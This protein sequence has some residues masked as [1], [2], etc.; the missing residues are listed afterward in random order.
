V[1]IV[2]GEG[3]VDALAKLGITATCCAEGAGKWRVEHAKWLAGA[4]VVILPDH[5]DRGREHRDT[6][7]RSLKGI[8]EHIRTL[9]LPGLGEKEDI[10]D[11]IKAGGTPE[12]FWQLVETLAVPPDQ[13]QKSAEPPSEDN[14]A[15]FVITLAEFLAKL[16]R[17]D[18]LV[19]TLLQRGFF[20]ALT[21]MTG[22]G[23]TAVAT[24]LAVVV[25]TRKPAQKFGPH[26]VKHGRVVYV[27]AENETD[28][29]MRFPPLL[30]M[31]GIEAA[32]LDILVIDSGF[33]LE[34]DF[35][36]IER[37]IRSFGDVDLMIVDTSPRLFTGTD[38][39]DD[40]QMLD[41]AVRMRGLT[42]LPGRPCVVALGHPIKHARAP[43][44][45]LPKGGGAYLNECDGNLTLW[46]HDAN[47]TDLHWTGKFRGPDFAP[48]TFRLG[49]AY[50]TTNVDKEGK[51]LP[52]VMAS[53]V[54]EAEVEAV[55]D[56][57]ARQEDQLLAALHHNPRGS[58]ADWATACGWFHAKGNDRQPNKQL[59]QRVA[60]R[61][62]K[63]KLL[64]KENRDY[65]LTRTGKAALNKKT[66]PEDASDDD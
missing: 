66:A 40:K 50:S 26:A 38:V 15:P 55:E 59:A 17:P 47:F 57:A 43:T 7:V 13:Y 48:I 25:A 31:F 52:T 35:R 24:L 12:A 45:L 61:L 11:W 44:D 19:D 56:G 51:L 5:D 10:I 20:Y 18:Y 39:N 6:V 64:A 46:K 49:I 28:V 63:A 42:R 53:Y 29:Q 27:A 60:D 4:D 22:G 16:V 36:L 62:V 23:K 2:E 54:T 1:L 32:D 34:K 58:L 65:V 21:G 37:E 30:N 14:S 3:K 41:H 8:A 33:D 9:E